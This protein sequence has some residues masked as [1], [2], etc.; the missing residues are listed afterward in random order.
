MLEEEY[1]LE[2]FKNQ[3]L[4]RKICKA[5][6]SAFW[7]RDSS[8]EICGDAPCEPYN[9]IGNP[10]FTA[11][12]STRCARPISPFLRRTGTPGS[13]ATRWPHA[14]GTIS[15]SPSH[16][17]RISSRLSP[18]GIVPPPAN[19]LTISQ[20][21][22]RL[23]DLDSVGQVRAA[24]DHVRDD[25]PPRLQ[26]PDRGDLLEGPDRRTLR[27][28]H[29]LHRRRPQQGHVQGE[30]VDWRRERRPERRGPDRRPRGRDPRLH[31]PRP[32][33]DRRTPA[34]IS[35]ARCTTR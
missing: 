20:P 23:N 6:G 12:P 29:C 21:C 17:S 9:F 30:P 3:G 32:A 8:R 16:P 2:Y 22:I 4:T 27:P 31:E 13:S 28:V 15:I 24:P 19:P 11:I 25:G 14:G 33:E 10:V 1:Q 35:T 18:S 5:C 26:H 34:T 7:T